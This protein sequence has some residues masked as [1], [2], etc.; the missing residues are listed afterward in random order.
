MHYGMLSITLPYVR[1]KQLPPMR[2]LLVKHHHEHSL[3]SEYLDHLHT[4]CQKS[5]RQ[6]WLSFQCN[7]SNIQPS[8][9]S[10]YPIFLVEPLEDPVCHRAGMSTLSSRIP[11]L[12]TDQTR[13]KDI[14]LKTSSPE[15][16]QTSYPRLLV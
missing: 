5:F 13:K 11:F 10:H 7:S 4:L 8:Q 2:H 6:L 12:M 3:I 16:V 1:I 14:W 15:L 9:Q